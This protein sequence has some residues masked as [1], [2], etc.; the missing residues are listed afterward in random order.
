MDTVEF[1]P[2]KGKIFPANDFLDANTLMVGKSA[3]HCD[4]A[5]RLNWRRF[6]AMPTLLGF[7]SFRFQMPLAAA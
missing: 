6:A 7:S 1:P 2:G 4:I 5:R 3:G